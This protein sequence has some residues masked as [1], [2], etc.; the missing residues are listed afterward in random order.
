MKCIGF[1][2]E[3]VEII[4]RDVFVYLLGDCWFLVVIVFFIVN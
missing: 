4:I 3:I 1:I 2:L